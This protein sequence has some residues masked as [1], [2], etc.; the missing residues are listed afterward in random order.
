MAKNKF[1][2][3][4]S[5]Y[6]K[7]PNKL[8]KNIIVNIVIV[9]IAVIYAFEYFNITPLNIQDL[10]NY[11]NTITTIDVGQGESTLIE[12]AGDYLLI[13]AGGDKDEN[14]VSHLYSRDIKKIDILLITHFHQDHISA[15]VDVLENFEV[16]KII[17]PNLSQENTPTTNTFQE[18]ILEIENQ[19]IPVDVA[20][21]GAEYI[22]GDGRLL[23]LADTLQDV[24]DINDTSIISLFTLNDFSYLST[25]DANSYAED[26]IINTFDGDVTMLN[27]AHHGSSDSTSEEF[28]DFISPEFAVI[29]AG[30]DNSYNHPHSETTTKLESRLIPYKITFN[31]GDTVYSM[32]N[33]AI[34]E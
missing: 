27:I 34:L 19:N 29:S 26:M 28:L 11:E 18:I 15:V 32:L 10:E 23:I 9:I 4:K 3:L 12:S 31:E 6:K 16:E 30:K 17:I 14:I 33:K 8:R 13:D 24:S 21:K 7:L 25:G 2:K 22:I 5:Q 20:Q 1:N